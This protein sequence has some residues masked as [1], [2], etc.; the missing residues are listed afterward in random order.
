MSPKYKIN[1]LIEIIY[2]IFYATIFFFCIGEESANQ[3][4]ELRKFFFF[5]HSAKTE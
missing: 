4:G 2:H 3:L 1:L 5:E